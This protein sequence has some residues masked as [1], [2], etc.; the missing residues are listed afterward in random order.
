M[1]ETKTS[2]LRVERGTES[3]LDLLRPLW[4]SLHHHHQ[5]IAPNLAPYIDDDFS[6][7]TRRRF[8]ADCL[9]HEGSF[10]LLALLGRGPHRLRPCPGTDDVLDVE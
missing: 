4:L 5:S 8:Y 3:R 10:V 7:R 1:N 9:S 6:W 2:N